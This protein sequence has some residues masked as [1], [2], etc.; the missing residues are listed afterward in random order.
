MISDNEF[1]KIMHGAGMTDP[2]ADTS[3]ARIRYMDLLSARGWMGASQK[4][5]RDQLLRE[6]HETDL[7]TLQLWL[8]EDCA[9]GIIHREGFGRYLI[10]PGREQDS[11]A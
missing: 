5:L 11:L 2:E 1:R 3:A 6:G 8:T 9:R 4:T 10:G 7:E